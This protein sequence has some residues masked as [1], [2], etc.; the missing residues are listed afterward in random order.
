MNI[1]SITFNFE[2]CD[3]LTID[4]RYIG[5]FSVADINTKIEKVAM[6][7]FLKMDT[8]DTIFMVIRKDANYDRYPFDDERLSD[9]K[10]TV[11][12]RLSYNDITSID[13]KLVD[14]KIPPEHCS[15]Y[16]KWIGDSDCI[17]AAQQV[18]VSSFGD[19]YL[20]ISDKE[21]ISDFYS[22]EEISDKHLR[23]MM[24]G[25]YA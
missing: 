17:N 8:A 23:K 20:L 12:K 2:N 25:L 21:K 24:F 15:Y 18:H 19:L 4:G 6:N 11:F 9:N 5:D 16:V 1:K 10:E 22:D 7:S 13:F 3:S 14:P